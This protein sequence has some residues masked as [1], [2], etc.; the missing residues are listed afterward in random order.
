[1]ASEDA[2]KLTHGEIVTKNLIFG[3]YRFSIKDFKNLREFVIPA[4][5]GGKKGE[6]HVG[7]S[8]KN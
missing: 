7:L 2:W 1:M 8:Y 3:F 6:I 4:K 5:L